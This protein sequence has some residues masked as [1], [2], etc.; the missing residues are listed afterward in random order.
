M[1]PNVLLVPSG[2]KVT[3]VAEDTGLTRGVMLVDDKDAL[4]VWDLLLPV[5]TSFI[6]RQAWHTRSVHERIHRGS[7]L[8][9]AS[10]DNLTYLWLDVP[11]LGTADSPVD[12]GEGTRNLAWLRVTSG[13]DIYLQLN[14][15]SIK[16]LMLEAIM[17]LHVRFLDVDQLA[18]TLQSMLFRWNY[19]VR[20]E[21]DDIKPL[22]TAMK[23]VGKHEFGWNTTL[24]GQLEVQWLAREHRDRTFQDL[25]DACACQTCPDCLGRAGLLPEHLDMSID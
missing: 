24:I 13:S 16:H 17:D 11:T 3:L 1:F 8:V 2:C 23:A 12:I 15:R 9:P 10:C 6:Y 18:Q 22:L 14:A 7:D 19:A 4:Q 5:C 25:F 20:A 21:D